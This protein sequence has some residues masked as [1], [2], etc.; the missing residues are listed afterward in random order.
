MGTKGNVYIEKAKKK[1]KRKKIMLLVLLLLAVGAGVAFKTDIFNIKNIKVSGEKGLTEKEVLEV[2][3]DIKGENIF[4][5]NSSNIIKRIKSLPY[6]D[7]VEVKKKY[8]NTVIF[9]MKEK[10]AAYYFKNGETFYIL[11]PDMQILDRVSELNIE[12]IIEIKNTEESYGDEGSYIREVK[13]REETVLK[14]FA[15]INE[16]ETVNN[17]ITALDTSNLG[18][19]KAYIGEIELLLGADEDLIDKMELV[20]D[21]LDNT[22]EVK[23]EKGYIDVRVKSAPVYLAK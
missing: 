20:F 17:K 7:S 16:L 21:I 11:S 5:F 19:I 3:K 10:S 8:P 1:R 2:S 12:N 4:L 6:V 18:D 23:I 9:D 14:L 15:N 22:E 13:E